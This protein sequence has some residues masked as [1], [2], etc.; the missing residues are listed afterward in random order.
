M[1]ILLDPNVC[2][3]LINGSHSGIRN[4][5]RE[6]R[7]RGE[8][9][10]VSSVS[11]FELWY[12]VQKSERV[13]RNA[14]RLADFLSPLSVLQFDEDDAFSAGR[15]RAVLERRGRQIG[16]FDYLIAGQAV[17]RDLLLVTA[18]IGEFSRIESLRWEDWS[19]TK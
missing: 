6:A 2:I 9:L 7:D 1:T 19:H 16:A 5:A 15:I 4:R 17:Q 3:A 14:E 8:T 18:K 12:G 11:L 10:A 13:E